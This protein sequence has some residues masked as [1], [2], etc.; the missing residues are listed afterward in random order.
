MEHLTPRSTLPPQ[1]APCPACS[2]G[3]LG[4]APATRARRSTWRLALRGCAAAGA[5]APLWRPGLAWLA[6]LA[7]LGEVVEELHLAHC[8][9]AHREASAAGEAPE[10]GLDA[11]QGL[12]LLL[13]VLR[14]RSRA[15]RGSLDPDKGEG[16]P[17]SNE[18]EACRGALQ[19]SAAGRG[20]GVRG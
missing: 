15:G 12:A 20:G 14:H 5:P 18:G 6:G 4:P 2:F 10:P 13:G 19:A 17:V 9:A 8:G 3:A 11:Q 7:G 1:G 16:L